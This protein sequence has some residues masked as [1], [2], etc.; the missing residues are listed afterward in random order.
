[1][2]QQQQQQWQQ[3]LQVADQ[4][5]A[6]AAARQQAALLG[7]VALARANSSAQAPAVTAHSVAWQWRLQRLAAGKLNT[8]AA[9]LATR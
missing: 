6:F 7:V 5:G 9:T 1:L 2:Q 8:M 3:W 4:T